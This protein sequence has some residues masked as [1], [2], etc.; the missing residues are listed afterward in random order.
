[1]QPLSDLKKDS[2]SD[3]W[4]QL[5]RA[6]Y[7]EQFCDYLMF[8]RNLAENTLLAYRRDIGSF[9]REVAEQGLTGPNEVEREM[10]EDYLNGLAQLPMKASSLA[11]RTSALRLYFRFLA[12]ENRITRDPTES[13]ELP[14][15]ELKLPTVLSLEEILAM[16][17]AIDRQAKGGLRDTALI[18][19]M[20]GTGM[21]VSEVV[22]LRL[23]DLKLPQQV[24]LIFGKG[25]KERVVPM[26]D[27]AIRALE[28][29]IELER[30]LLD[31]LGRGAG[32]VFLN[33]RNGSPITRMG[34]WK[35]LHKYAT[36]AGIAHKVH[37]HVLRHSFATHLV[38]NGADLRSVQE[39]LGHADIATTKIYSHL[40]NE[41]LRQ[42]HR[43]FHPRA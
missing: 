8:E 1:M 25:S 11:R 21:R 31:R 18:E 12:G 19:L 22:G 30:P 35:I 32:K 40:G 5:F 38:E 36:L 7:F 10:V 37:P 17:K 3:K 42:V 29:Y 39:M 9:I 43:E 24:V 27:I 26:G 6:F 41:T 20:Y 15:K 23:V 4:D 2:D 16:L 13:I 14:R 34:I 28:E 33:L